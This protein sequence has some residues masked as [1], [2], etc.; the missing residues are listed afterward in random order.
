MGEGKIPRR[1]QK[2]SNDRFA[3]AAFLGG[4]QR[5]APSVQQPERHRAT[6]APQPSTFQSSISARK[7]HSHSL[8]TD[9][10][11]RVWSGHRASHPPLARFTA[12]HYVPC[13][14][15]CQYCMRRGATRDVALRSSIDSGHFVS[16]LLIQQYLNELSDLRRV[17]GSARE[18]VVREAFK[19]LLK[20]W[21]RSQDLI[22]VPE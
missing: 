21:G 8:G 17:S 14:F 10:Q 5:R 20:G 6:A 16:Q 12:W 1:L 9:L 4:V 3:T 7:A 18:S 15:L 19:T 22:F 2:I 13:L 11:D